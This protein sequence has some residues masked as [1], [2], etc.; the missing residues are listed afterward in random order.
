MFILS[1]VPDGRRSSWE[2]RASQVSASEA[3]R[4][5]ASS[6]EGITQQTGDVDPIMGQYCFVFVLI[7]QYFDGYTCVMNTRM[8]YEY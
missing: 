3:T 6:D 7:H 4:P 5:L 8:N 2:N 1:K